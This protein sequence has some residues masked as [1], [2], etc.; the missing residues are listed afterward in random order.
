[1]P[2]RYETFGMVAAEALAVGTP[3]VAF[4]IPCL[5]ALVDE[6]VGARTAAFDV[7]AFAVALRSLCR[8][9]DM[10]RRL[11]AAGPARVTG[12]NWD[13]LAAAQGRVYQALLDGAEDIASAGGGKVLPI[14]QSS[15][16]G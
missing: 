12:L 8:D 5:R 3:V 7:D 10:R 4:D 9:E 2:S 16:R 1:M 14:R 6:G 11:G 15:A 13:D